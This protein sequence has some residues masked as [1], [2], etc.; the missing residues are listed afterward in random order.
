MMQDVK[1]DIETNH[2]NMQQKLVLFQKNVFHINH[3]EVPHQPVHSNA[4]AKACVDP[5][6]PY[7]KYFGRSDFVNFK[8]IETAMNNLMTYGPIKASFKVYRDFF[9]YKKGV[10]Q[11]KSGSFAGG[12]AV[13]VVGWGVDSESG[14]DYWNIANSWGPNWGMSGFFWI[15]KGS[16]ECEIENGLWT[17]YADTTK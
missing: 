5:K 6:I 3:Q 7:K 11:F 17:G 13:R 14:L 9:N 10:Y 2:G 1:V 4:T 15:K 8:D 12:H 16:N